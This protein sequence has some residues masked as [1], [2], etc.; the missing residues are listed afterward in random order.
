MAVPDAQTERLAAHARWAVAQLRWTPA[1]SSPREAPGAPPIGPY[2]RRGGATK[3]DPVTDLASPLDRSNPN[4]ADVVRASMTYLR[5]SSR[6]GSA[7]SERKG[8]PAGSRP[9]S[10]AGSSS[11][12]PMMPGRAHRTK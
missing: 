2:T 5:S 6:S 3:D 9:W 8:S 11:S 10:R 1:P 12:S 4:D 7:A